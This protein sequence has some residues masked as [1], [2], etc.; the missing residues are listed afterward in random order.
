MNTIMRK[1]TILDSVAAPML[2]ANINTDFIIRAERCV[3]VK[4]EDL[5]FYAFEAAR[6]LR[7]DADVSRS[8][9]NPA[10][11]FN[12]E[13]FRGARIILGGPNFGCGSSRETAVRALEGL[14]IRCIIAPSFGEIFA[15]NCYQNG[16]ATIRLPLETVAR[17]GELFLAQASGANLSVDLA[18]QLIRCAD[19]DEIAFDYDP[20]QKR[21]LLEG[22][23]EI[24]M[25]LAMSDRIDAFQKADRIK[26]SWIYLDGL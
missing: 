25:T 20:L 7:V 4:R 10:F 8:E 24:S 21:A 14:G 12:R 9:E 5:G 2:E 18:R 23:D 26:R 17:L 22:L 16:I 6:Y 13:P 19:G 15:G 1:F 3:Y 11:V